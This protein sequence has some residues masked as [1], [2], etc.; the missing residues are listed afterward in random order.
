MDGSALQYNIVRVN[1]Q[2]SVYVP[3]LKQGGDTNTIAVVDGI[4]SAIKTLRDI[5]SQLKTHVVFD[6]SLFVKQAIST[7]LREGGVG[8]AADGR[9][10]PG[11]PGQPASDG[12]CVSFDSA[13][14]DGDAFSSCTRATGPSTA[15]C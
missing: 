5:P 3:I 15:W 13:F 1:G 8:L 4:R 9:A 6:Q 12:G 2:R 14:G 7:V 10:D 11:F